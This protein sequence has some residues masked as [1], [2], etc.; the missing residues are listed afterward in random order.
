MM[1]DKKDMMHHGHVLQRVLGFAIDPDW[2]GLPGLCH[3]P[4]TIGRRALNKIG[5]QRIKQ[6]LEFPVVALQRSIAF[7]C[8]GKMGQAHD[9][10]RFDVRIS[11]VCHVL[12]RLTQVWS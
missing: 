12:V 4:Q 1:K 5:Q 7:A 3:P 10:D 6:I 9:A 2:A 8:W 11:C